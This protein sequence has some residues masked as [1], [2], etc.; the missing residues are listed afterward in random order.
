MNITTVGIDLA[1]NILQV[2]GVDERG[3]P[4]LRKSLK[5]SQVASFFANLPVCLIGIEAC[6]S[7]HHWA[8]KLQS[9]G[10]DV[11]MNVPQFVKPYVKSNTNGPP[12][13]FQTPR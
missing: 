10:H 9:F 8:R 12:P 13:R 11:R 1:K 5:W 3:K 6:G 4:V 2:H 7:D